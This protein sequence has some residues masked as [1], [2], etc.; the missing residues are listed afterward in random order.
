M[1]MR[2]WTETPDSAR[3]GARYLAESDGSRARGAGL[4]TQPGTLLSK[5]RSAPVDSE[6]RSGRRA[7]VPAVAGARR[8]TPPLWA[9]ALGYTGQ[10]KAWCPVFRGRL[11]R[12]ATKASH[13]RRARRRSSRLETETWT[14][15]AHGISRRAT[16]RGR[17]APAPRRGPEHGYLS[18]D[19]RPSS[20][21]A[22]ARSAFARFGE[23]H[24]S[25]AEI[26][27]AAVGVE[28]PGAA[29]APPEWRKREA[30]T[31]AGASGARRHRTAQAWCPDS[32]GRPPLVTR[33]SIYIF[34][35]IPHPPPHTH[36]ARCA[37]PRLAPT[38][39]SSPPRRR[40]P[41]GAEAPA[42]RRGFP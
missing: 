18:S 30:A 5:Q 14:G 25:G 32:G 23:I 3:R 20:R 36:F 21:S 12:K 15:V 17:E 19:P 13:T 2:L 33:G 42:H 16:G 40:L 38:I 34:L 24:Q 28:M 1:E 27:A 4:S 9:S 7:C 41:A 29:S 26:P 10:R 39:A 6:S 31:T 35:P 37:L 8:R 11:R 22:S